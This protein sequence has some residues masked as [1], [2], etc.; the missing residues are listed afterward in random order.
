MTLTELICR[1]EH[2]QADHPDAIP[3]VNM[4]RNEYAN[5]WEVTELVVAKAKRSVERRPGHN[6]WLTDYTPGHIEPGYE[7]ATVINIC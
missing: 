3:V 2:L 1:L 6:R 5:G 4:G 7:Y